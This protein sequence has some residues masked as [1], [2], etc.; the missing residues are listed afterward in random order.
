MISACAFP[1]WE[2][3]AWWYVLYYSDVN[4]SIIIIYEVFNSYC[5]AMFILGHVWIFFLVFSHYCI[6]EILE[7]SHLEAII[8]LKYSIF[9][10]MFKNY[11]ARIVSEFLPSFIWYNF[12]ILMF[13][14]LFQT[15]S[16]LYTTCIFSDHYL[17][18]MATFDRLC[19][20]NEN[21]ILTFPFKVAAPG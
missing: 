4:K 12:F 8:M 21:R 20:Q 3:Q 7:Y 11:P 13:E 10:R 5:Y 1:L 18:K 17:N 16:I 14:K 2:T 6:S 19:E 9:R 15:S